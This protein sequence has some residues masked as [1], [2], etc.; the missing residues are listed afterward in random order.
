M[1]SIGAEGKARRFQTLLTSRLVDTIVI[2]DLDT[3]RP[4]LAGRQSLMLLGCQGFLLAMF[5]TF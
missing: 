2:H 5:P 1:F 4:A 3:V